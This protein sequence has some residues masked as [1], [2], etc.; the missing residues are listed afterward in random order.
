MINSIF[1]K[2]NLSVRMNSAVV[3]PVLGEQLE[4]I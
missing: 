3:A 1:D 4:Q 2:S